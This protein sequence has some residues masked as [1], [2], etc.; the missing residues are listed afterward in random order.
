MYP[1]SKGPYNSGR[2]LLRHADRK[3]TSYSGAP[4]SLHDKTLIYT[5]ASF[6]PNTY[7]AGLAW[8]IMGNHAPQSDESY[9]VAA[10]AEHAELQAMYFAL[11]HIVDNDEGV[12]QDVKHIELIS[13]CGNAV[14]FLRGRD[15]PLDDSLRVYNDILAVAN[16]YGWT[17]HAQWVRGHTQT[18]TL[19]TRINRSCD[20]RAKSMMRHFRRQLSAEETE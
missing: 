9:L 19:S 12:F 14:N 4:L 13:D 3:R 7:A 5:D 11:L 2:R 1:D 6:C 16:Y 17:L 15:N 10:S 8:T 20:F 18:Q